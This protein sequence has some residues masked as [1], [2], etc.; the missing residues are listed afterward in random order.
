MFD[1]NKATKRFLEGKK[2]FLKESAT[3]DRP[4]VDD[5]VVDYE[6]GRIR[7][8]VFETLMDEKVRTAVLK[9]GV[10]EQVDSIPNFKEVNVESEGGPDYHTIVP[11]LG[12]FVKGK[13]LFVTKEQLDKLDF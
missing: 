5:T 3:L 12:N 11:E 1:L 4:A 6:K 13:I 9:E 2:A 10:E 7:C 8:F